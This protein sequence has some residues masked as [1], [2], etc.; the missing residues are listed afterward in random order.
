MCACQTPQ[1]PQ[2]WSDD[3]AESV[4]RNDRCFW[5]I[6]GAVIAA[7]LAGL[8]GRGVAAYLAIDIDDGVPHY[9]YL[10]FGLLAFVATWVATWLWFSRKF[11]S[12]PLTVDRDSGY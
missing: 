11:W 12:S 9:L 1:T 2:P 7:F 10:G 4:R 6:M 3:Y 8:L 5:S